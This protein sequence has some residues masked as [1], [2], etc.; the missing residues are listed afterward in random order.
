MGTKSPGPRAGKHSFLHSLWEVR[1]VGLSP[2]CFV[3]LWRYVLLWP[4]TTSDWMTWPGWWKSVVVRWLPL[5]FIAALI[6]SFAAEGLSFSWS[7]LPF[8]AR[9]RSTCVVST[10]KRSTSAQSVTRPSVALTS[11]D[12]TCFGIQT[13]KTSC[14]LP[15]GSSLRYVVN[16]QPEL[17]LRATGLS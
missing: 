15:V 8:T 16:V 17:G 7:L 3:S 13:A 10:Q 14:V 9:W 11:C 5:A 1:F 4:V 6:L 2:T 12:S